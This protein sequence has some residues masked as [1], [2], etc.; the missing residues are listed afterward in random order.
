M[1]DAMFKSIFNMMSQNGDRMGVDGD[2]VCMHVHIIIQ[3]HDC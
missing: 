2:D 3:T 1:A